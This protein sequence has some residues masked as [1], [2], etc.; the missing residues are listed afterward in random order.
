[1]TDLQGSN[2]PC[3]EAIY[4]QSSR[5]VLDCSVLIADDLDEHPLSPASIEFP[6]EDLLPGAEVKFASGYGNHH[7]AAHDLPFHVGVGIV[8]AAVVVP[9]LV[10]RLVGGELFEPCGVVAME[11]AFVVVNEHGSGDM[12]RVDKNEPL[13]NAAFMKTFFDLSRDVD[14]GYAR[15]GIEPQ[16]FSIAFQAVSPLFDGCCGRCPRL[17]PASLYKLYLRSRKD[18]ATAPTMFSSVISMSSCLVNW[19]SLPIISSFSARMDA[20]SF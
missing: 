1:M 2:K 19:N 13:P 9:I 7:F 15:W 8:F 18:L 4:E 17:T 10:Y 20:S 16:L 12:H 14:E 5:P 6:V 3:D 11:S